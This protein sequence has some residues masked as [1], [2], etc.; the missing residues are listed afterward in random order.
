MK[1]GIPNH[2]VYESTAAYDR[3]LKLILGG[4]LALILV[5]RVISRPGDL[6]STW[7]PHP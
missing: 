6:E 2:V 1:T 5:M 4:V 3:W 7:S